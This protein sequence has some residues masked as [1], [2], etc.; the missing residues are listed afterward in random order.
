M[1]SAQISFDERVGDDRR[2]FGRHASALKCLPAKA[3]EGCRLNN[4]IFTCR[5]SHD[6]PFEAVEILLLPCRVLRILI[7]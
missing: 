3:A 6:I 7:P 4:Y 5:Y 1:D 2:F